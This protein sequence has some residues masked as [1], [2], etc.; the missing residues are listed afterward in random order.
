[1][2]KFVITYNGT[3]I[4]FINDKLKILSKLNNIIIYVTSTFFYEY[5]DCPK[6]GF[7]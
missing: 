4:K 2:E 6:V 5:V 7:L 3:L 1:M